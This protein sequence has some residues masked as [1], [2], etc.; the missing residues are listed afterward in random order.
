[1]SQGTFSDT[2]IRLEAFKIM[3]VFRPKI[4]FFPSGLCL[5]ICQPYF[6]MKSKMVAP[7]NLTAKMGDNQTLFC[8]TLKYSFQFP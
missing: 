7:E 4:D 5:N 8:L 2:L 3:F 1:M 6:I